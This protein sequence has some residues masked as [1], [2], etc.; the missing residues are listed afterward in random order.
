[1]HASQPPLPQVQ[2]GDGPNRGDDDATHGRRC[3]RP[4]ALADDWTDVQSSGV[5]VS[6]CG[7]DPGVAACAGLREWGRQ[8][9]FPMTWGRR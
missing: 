5:Y 3:I 6:V 8:Q 1:M 2:N 4:P 7:E 9:G